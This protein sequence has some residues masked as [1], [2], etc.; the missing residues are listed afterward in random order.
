LLGATWLVQFE[1]VF[2][3]LVWIVVALHITGLLPEL[4]DLLESVKFSAPAS[5]S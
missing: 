2:S 5:R 4:I 1:R 3:L